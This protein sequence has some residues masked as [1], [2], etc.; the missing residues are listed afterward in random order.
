MTSADG[1][2]IDPLPPSDLPSAV[3]SVAVPIRFGHCDPAGIVFT[4]RYFEILN[5][6][7]EQFFGAALGLN[8]YHIVTARKIGLGYVQAACEFMK[9]SRMGEVLE[10]AVLVERI[11][12]SSY[13]LTLPI[14]K[15]D[16]EVARGRLVTVATSLET[17]KAL[18]IPEDIR[19]ALDG[20]RERCTSSKTS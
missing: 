8:Y 5:E 14:L 12:R 2:R 13:T 15:D 19:A 16:V 4:P 1:T 20:Y 10:V 3:W 11:G 18:K 6:A 17:Y 9:P 7:V